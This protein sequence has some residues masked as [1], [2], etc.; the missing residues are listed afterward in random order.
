MLYYLFHLFIKMKNSQKILYK[1]ANFLKEMLPRYITKI[2]LNNYELEVTINLNGLLPT[3]F[4]L[5]NHTNA[6]FNILTDIIALDFPGKKKRF[7]VIYHLLSIHYNCRLSVRVEVAELEAVDSV[8]AIFNSAGWQERE[9]W[10]LFGIVFRNHPDLRRILTD[11]GFKGHPLR[12]DFPL[13]GYIEIFY[14]DSKRRIVYAPVSLAQEYRNFT[15]N[16]PW[17]SK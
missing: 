1:Y 11:Y 16:N 13:T 3:L 4:F 5:K 10:D 17:Q 2:K 12:K 15:F 6:K 7:L 9:V 14:D 8:T